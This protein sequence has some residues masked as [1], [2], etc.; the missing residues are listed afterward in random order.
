V[1]TFLL[2]SLKCKTG[3]HQANDQYQKI[4]QICKKR[5]T[6]D[7]DYSNNDS[8]SED[9][10]KDDSLSVDLFGTRFFMNGG[11]KFFMQSWNEP[12]ENR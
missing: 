11:N 6:T 9:D 2:Q 1:Y 4:M 8:S 5:S 7:N 10:D 12:N 3:V